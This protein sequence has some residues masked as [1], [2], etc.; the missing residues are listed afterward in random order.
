M[1]KSGHYLRSDN[2]D[3]NLDHDILKPTKLY[4][5]AYLS[6]TATQNEWLLIN[7]KCI[8]NQYSFAFSYMLLLLSMISLFCL[9]VNLFL[10]LMEEIVVSRLN[11]VNNRKSDDFGN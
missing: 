2:Q 1:K 5:N 11:E 6:N 4:F 8:V 9:C 3:S 7:I 10:D